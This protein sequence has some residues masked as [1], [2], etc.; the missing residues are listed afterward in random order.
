MALLVRRVRER[1]QPENLLCIGTS[2]TMAS[3]G[4]LEDKNRVVAGVASKLFG[5]EIAESN[6]IDVFNGLLLA[7]HLDAAFDSG[8]ITIA[9][10]GTVLVSDALPSDARS[11]L[12]L[13]GPLKVPG[14][15][16]AH[17]R[18]MSWHRSRIFRT[19][20]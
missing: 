14:L 7:P 3:E 9:E 15:H 1:L 18:Y 20:V 17:G 10:D 2:A 19:G 8:F 4:S 5:N 12:G 6:V 13:D 11:A 16:H